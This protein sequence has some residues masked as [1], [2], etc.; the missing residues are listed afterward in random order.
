[1]IGP[2]PADDS[3]ARRLAGMP[4]PRLA[5]P[6]TSGSTVDLSAREGA[7]VVYVYPWTGRPGLPDPPGWDEI[8]GAHGSTPETAGFR[9]CHPQFLA[10]EVEVFGLSTQTGAHQ[11]EL[12]ARLGLPFALLSDESFAFQRALRLPTFAAG[13]GTYLRRLTLFIRNGR[14]GRVFYPVP[15]PETHAREVLDWVAGGGAA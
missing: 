3:A 8:P 5:L 12:S 7:A 2:V 14:I 6:S 4:L 10:L 1:M 9:D 13:G 11:H 15:S